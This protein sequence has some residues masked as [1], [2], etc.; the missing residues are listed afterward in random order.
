MTQ[1]EHSHR[2]DDRRRSVPYLRYFTIAVLICCLPFFALGATI[3]ATGTV[4]VDVQEA[5]PEGASLW[6]PV[7]M[8]LLDLAIFAAPRLMPEDALDEARAEIEPYLPAL[9]EFAGALEDCPDGI[10]VQVEGEDEHV[11]ISKEGRNFKI[12]VESADADIDVSVP[13]RVLSRTLDLFG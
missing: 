1:I 9:Q 7:P 2:P 4:M 12:H 11:L 3:A 10:L 6:I 5:G 8:L 13:T